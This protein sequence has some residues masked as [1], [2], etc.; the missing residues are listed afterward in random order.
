MP[1]LTTGAVESAMEAYAVNEPQAKAILGAMSIKGFALIQG[2]V[3][4]VCVI[5]NLVAEIQQTPRYRKDQDDKRSSREIPIG[6]QYPHPRQWS[7]SGQ[8]ETPGLCSE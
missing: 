8:A 1:H 6:T 5:E 4:V 2:S 7:K 3:N